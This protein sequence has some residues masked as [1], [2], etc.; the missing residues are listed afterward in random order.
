MH[1]SLVRFWAD[2]NSFIEKG[3][4]DAA[5]ALPDL[6]TPD[7]STDNSTDD[8]SSAPDLLAFSQ[9]GMHNNN[10]EDKDTSKQAAIVKPR[11]AGGCSSWF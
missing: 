2:A 11:Q 8:E 1:R 3:H 5:D 7:A 4:C 6:L 10:K 9:F